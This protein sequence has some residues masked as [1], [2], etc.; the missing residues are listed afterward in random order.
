M[1]PISQMT[2]KSCFCNSALNG[3]LLRF[4]RNGRSMLNSAM[5]E[6][7]DTV[8]Y[9]TY[10]YHNYP[11]DEILTVLKTCRTTKRTRIPITVNAD[12]R[13]EIPNITKSDEYKTKTMQVMLREHLMTHISK[14]FSNTLNIRMCLIISGYV[15]G[16]KQM[17][18]SWTWLCANPSAWIMP[19]CAPDGFTWA[20]PSKICIGDIHQ[21]LEHWRERKRHRLNP[22]IWVKS[23]PVFKDT[24]LLLDHQ[25]YDSDGSPDASSPTGDE[26][27][28]R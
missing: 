22:L 18:I 12:G 14:S 27:D 11:L 4:L 16:R 9:E 6:V 3:G 10:I 8:L 19:E 1:K 24:D 5:A 23:C 28:G 26:S 17:R 15:S 2:F 13:P 25:E 7:C 20:D 21:L